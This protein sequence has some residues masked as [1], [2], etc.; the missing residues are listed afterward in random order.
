MG[1]ER[2]NLPYI[3]GEIVLD[4]CANSECYQIKIQMV[5]IMNWT[6]SN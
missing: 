2:G 6:Y 1:G 3:L 4:G 5:I